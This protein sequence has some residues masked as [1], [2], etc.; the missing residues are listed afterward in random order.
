MTD[1]LLNRDDP[2]QAALA[3]MARVIEWPD[4][5]PLAEAVSAAIRT[6][7]QPVRTAWRPARRGLVLGLAATLLLASVAAAI[8]IALG[9]L[10]II[11]GGPP[12]G[13][14]LP[15]ALVAERGFGA[16]TDLD[17]AARSLGVLLVPELAALGDPDHVF[18]DTRTGAAALTWGGREGLP[19]DP[20]TGL[21][22]VVT[23]FPADIG[24]TTFEKLI[25]DGTQVEQVVVG[26]TT[27]YWIEGGEHFFYFRLA[28]GDVLETTIRLVGTT[29]MWER[30]GLTV[31]IE[32]A[33]SMVDAVRIA[34]SMSLR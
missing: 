15:D 31:R 18:F 14:P 8:G 32:G 3:D 2:L 34:E 20:D 9:G 23:Q 12:P 24:P 26:S 30:D 13:T 22:I 28:D 21:G 6:R 29:L 4:T 5:P 10:R 33:P 16:E 1:R 25:N 17:G 7:P 27:G 19:A 11:T